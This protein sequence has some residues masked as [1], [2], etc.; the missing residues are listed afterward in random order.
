MD[1]DK[2]HCQPIDLETGI[3]VLESVVCSIES[4]ATFVYADGANHVIEYVPGIRR[5]ISIWGTANG[6]DYY[7]SLR[8]VDKGPLRKPRV[9]EGT[10]YGFFL[11]TDFAEISALLE[12]DKMRYVQ[13]FSGRF[14]G[15]ERHTLSLQMK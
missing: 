10:L 11:M 3:E 12:S 7:V 1:T 8:F 2:E 15:E 9:S 5:L 6:R 13:Y 4:Y 14:E